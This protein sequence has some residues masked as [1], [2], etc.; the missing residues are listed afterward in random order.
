[1]TN[2]KKR[3]PAMAIVAGEPMSSNIRMTC[4]GLVDDFGKGSLNISR[5]LMASLEGATLRLPSSS[6]YLM[7]SS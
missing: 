5:L 4:S 2:P 7:A 3:G 1:M 6:K